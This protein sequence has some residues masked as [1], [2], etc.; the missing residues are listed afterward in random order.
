ML[1]L[2]SLPDQWWLVPLGFVLGTFG[3]LIGAGG[4]FVLVPLL[5][6]LYPTEK[7]DVITAISL[8]VVFLNS[9]SGSIAYASMKRIDYKSGIIFSLAT[10]PGAILGALGTAYIPRKQFDELFGVLMILG[11]MFLVIRPISSTPR[12]A[13]KLQMARKVVDV[14]GI[15]Y[16]F[17]Y[18]P[19]LGITLSLFVGFLSS[20][21]GV[22]GGFIHVPALVYLLN[23]PVHVATATSHFILAIM[24]FTGT[25]VHILTGTFTRIIGLTILL[26]IGVL[27][28]A[29][30]GAKLSTRVNAQW[31]LRSL[32][33]ALGFVGIRLIFVALRM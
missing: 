27:P 19:L 20:F 15:E 31:I 28:G 21:L 11:S 2:E 29:Q 7:P 25:V 32:A 16:S 26:G 24:T 23:F 17:S 3:T 10:V 9:F 14:E 18:N 33:T 22:G 5:L 12:F 4:G 6:L 30:F 1:A 8:A 13:S